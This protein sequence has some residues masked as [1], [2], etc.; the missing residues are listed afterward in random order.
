MDFFDECQVFV[1]MLFAEGD[2]QELLEAFGDVVFEPFAFQHRDDVVFIGYE[3]GLGDLLQIVLQRFALIC[4]HQTWLIERVAP[5]HTAHGV[6]DEFL[7]RIGTQ[8]F[9]QPFFVL[10][11]P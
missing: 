11:P 2:A 6:T 10:L 5:E 8:E 1:V 3:G 7:H 9:F 4:Q